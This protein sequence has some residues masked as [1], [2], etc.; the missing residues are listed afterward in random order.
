MDQ[1]ETTE[2]TEIRIPFSILRFLCLLLLSAA[3]ASSLVCS[4]KNQ[5]ANAVSDFQRKTSPLSLLS[6]VQKYP[7]ASPV[8]LAMNSYCVMDYGGKELFCNKRRILCL[9]MVR[10]K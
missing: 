5:L 9:Y 7:V 10:W 2:G 6:P 1:Q 4:W 3:S 8:Q